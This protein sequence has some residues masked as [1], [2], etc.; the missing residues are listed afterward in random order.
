MK[1][2]VRGK[3]SH[4]RKE[5]TKRPKSI[6]EMAK[7]V[8]KKFKELVYEFDNAQLAIHPIKGLKVV[9]DLRLVLR[10]REVHH[11]GRLVL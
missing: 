3:R 5:G 10:I 6:Q 9:D 2:E 7:K 8:Y 4:E 1:I 11:D